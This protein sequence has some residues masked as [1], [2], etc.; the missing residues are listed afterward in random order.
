MNHPLSA[1]AQTHGF[2]LKAFEAFAV[3]NE[4]RF[5]VFEE[6]CKWWVGTWHVDELIKEFKAV[7]AQGLYVD[8]EGF[9]QF[10]G[11]PPEGLHAVLR[12]KQCNG[13]PYVAVDVVGSDGFVRQTAVRHGSVADLE[14][15]G[16]TVVFSWMPV[17]HKDQKSATA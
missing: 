1:V 13:Q 6:F 14:K 4:A 16:V 2:E 8:D 5:G 7:A 11:F 17:A 3:R 15:E 12:S 9:T 10:V